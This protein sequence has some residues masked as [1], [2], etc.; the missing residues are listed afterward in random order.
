MIATEIWLAIRRSQICG[1]QK[2]RDSSCPC[3][4]SD[5]PAGYPMLLRVIRCSCGLS[6]APVGYL[7]GQVEQKMGLH[8]VITFPPPSLFARCLVLT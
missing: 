4:L 2:L 5:A 6:D 7:I 3:G 8:F 1:L